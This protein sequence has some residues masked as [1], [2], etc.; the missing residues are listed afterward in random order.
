LIK[1]AQIMASTGCSPAMAQSDAKNGNL[2]TK[3]RAE[4][5]KTLLHSTIA[6]F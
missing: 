2:G 1:R 4:N 5:G 6:N 3:I